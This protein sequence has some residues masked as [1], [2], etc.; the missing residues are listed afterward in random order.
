[1]IPEEFRGTDDFLDLVTWN[2]RFFHH[3]D[4]KRV[5]R[6]TEILSVLNADIIILR[7]A[8]PSVCRPRP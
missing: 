8:L 1:M 4:R 3:H 2:I 7:R 5:T 6:I